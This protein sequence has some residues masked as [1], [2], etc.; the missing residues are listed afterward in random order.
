V[1]NL[2]NC[3]VVAVPI[4]WKCSEIEHFTKRAVNGYWV[5][6]FEDLT[7]I[8]DQIRAELLIPQD[9]YTFTFETN[10]LMDELLDRF[11]NLKSPEKKFLVTG[12]KHNILTVYTPHLENKTEFQEAVQQCT[13]TSLLPYTGNIQTA[14][15]WI[16]EMEIDLRLEKKSINFVHA[17]KAKGLQYVLVSV[18]P[19][20]M[21]PWWWCSCSFSS[22]SE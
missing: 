20:F 5:V 3:S 19:W 8:E 13:K 2:H 16:K 1:V 10:V 6:E 12:E 17:F 14:R 4:E 11:Q 15:E 21:F 7:K 22:V 18:D 9:S